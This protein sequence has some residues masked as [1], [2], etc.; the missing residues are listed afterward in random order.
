MSPST[1][2]S[3][4]LSA[5]SDF[6]LMN[7]VQQQYLP[8]PCIKSDLFFKL[9]AATTGSQFQSGGRKSS[10]FHPEKRERWFTFFNQ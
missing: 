5:I 8:Q 7:A 10:Y 6:K 4:L 9:L 3:K 2:I 1:V